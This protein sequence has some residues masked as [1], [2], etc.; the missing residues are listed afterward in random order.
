MKSGVVLRIEKSSIFDGDGLR[1]VVFLK[2][3]PLSC[4]WCSTPESQNPQIERAGERVFGR[5]MSV[6]Q[7]MTEVCKDEVF[8]FH[9]GGGLTLSGGEPLLQADFAAALLAECR[10]LGINTAIETSLCLPFSEMEK[11][12]PYLDLAFVDLKLMDPEQHRR[13]CGQDNRLILSNIRRLAAWQWPL[14]LV[15]RTPLIPGINDGDHNLAE[16]GRFCAGL[17]R[18]RAVELLPYHRLGLHTYAQLGRD[19]PLPQV[20]VPAA[21]QMAERRA[22]LRRYLRQVRVQ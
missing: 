17:P 21:D 12:L 9:S 1:T 13:Y 18:L 8:F 5:V 20:A 11:L 10:R 2:G 16:L 19:Y 22:F 3:C 15:I 7:V 4:Q 6:E 14:E